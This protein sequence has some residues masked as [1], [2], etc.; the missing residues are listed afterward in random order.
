M[1]ADGSQESDIASNHSYKANKS[2]WLYYGLQSSAAGD[3]N[4]SFPGGKMT[5]HSALHPDNN[6]TDSPFLR[7]FKGKLSIK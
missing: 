4:K 7:G 5:P 1:Y 2:R 6:P 3:V